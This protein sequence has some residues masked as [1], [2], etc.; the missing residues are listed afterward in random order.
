MPISR[1]YERG[2]Q[3]KNSPLLPCEGS[4]PTIIS[5]GLGGA[6]NKAA[7]EFLTHGKYLSQLLR[8]TPSGKKNFEA[9]I[10]SSAVNGNQGQPQLLALETW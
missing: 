7:V 2:C 10:G 4:Q 6:G 1:S 5:A 3:E 9:V 8:A